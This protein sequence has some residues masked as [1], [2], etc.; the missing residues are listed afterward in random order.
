M[1]IG[2]S[3]HSGIFLNIFLHFS[4]ARNSPERRSGPLAHDILSSLGNDTED[5][6]RPVQQDEPTLSN[7]LSQQESNPQNPLVTSW[8]VVLLRLMSIGKTGYE[9]Q[10]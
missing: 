9:L 6:T 5:A 7:D 8:S 10:M 1:I 4:E 3:R 2:L